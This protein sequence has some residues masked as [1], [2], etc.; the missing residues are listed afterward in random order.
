MKDSS[1]NISIAELLKKIVDG[2]DAKKIGL[3]VFFDL[4]KAFDLVDH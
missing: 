2:M 1:T 4:Q 3:C